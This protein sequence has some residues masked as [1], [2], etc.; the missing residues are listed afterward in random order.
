MNRIPEVT[1]F[2]V[3]NSNE[4]GTWSNIPYFFTQTLL[5]KGVVIN[6]VNLEPPRGTLFMARIAWKLLGMFYRNPTYTYLRS[7]WYFNRARRKIAEAVARHTNSQVDIFITFSFSSAGLTDRPIVQF[8]DWTFD[9]QIQHFENRRPDRW[10]QAC[11][12]REDA[13]IEGADLVIS[14]FPGITKYMQGRY[15]NDNIRYLGNVVNATHGMDVAQTIAAKSRSMSIVFIGKEKYKEGARLLIAAF[16]ELRK[17]YPA[18]SVDIIGMTAGDFDGVPDGVACHGVLDK[19]KADEKEL[20]YRLLA[21]AR[22]FVNTTANWGGFSASLEALHFCTPVVVRPYGEFR[23][24]FG[25]P[26]DF[27]RYSHDGTVGVLKENIAAILDHPH[28][29]E[30]CRNAHRAVRNFT[31]DAYI[32]RLMDAIAETRGKKAAALK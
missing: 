22:V 4:V 15:R 2:T 8:C 16:H 25:D 28:Y 6:R 18:L 30:L 1:V 29:E 26:I 27:G 13:Q 7:P 19:G 10:E 9:Y 31:W 21:K 23:E 17:Q 14:L 3:G 11:I 32:D 20:F 5:A 12:R 24:T